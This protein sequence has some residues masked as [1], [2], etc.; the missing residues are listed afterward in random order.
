M[1]DAMKLTEVAKLDGVK[2][3]PTTAKG[4]FAKALKAEAAGDT[5]EAARLLDAAVAAVSKK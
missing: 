4:Y 2:D 1:F 3:L 5:V